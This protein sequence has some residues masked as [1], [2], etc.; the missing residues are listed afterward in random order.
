MSK[1]YDDERA[2]IYKEKSVRLTLEHPLDLSA[3]ATSRLFVNPI[4]KGCRAPARQ[5][6]FFTQVIEYGHYTRFTQRLNIA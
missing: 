6:P 1:A 3:D 5:P 2:E 4:I